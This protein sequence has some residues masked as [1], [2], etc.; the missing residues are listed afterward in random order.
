MDDPQTCVHSRA[1]GILVFAIIAAFAPSLCAQKFGRETLTLADVLD[2]A[3]ELAPQLPRVGLLPG[4]TTVVWQVQEMPGRVEVV[5]RVDL[6]TRGTTRLFNGMTLRIALRAA[7]ST[8]PDDGAVPPFSFL[9][10]DRVRVETEDGVW[11]WRFG[12]VKAERLLPPL[13][14]ATAAA[15]APGDV[16]VAGIVDADLKVLDAAGREQRVTWDGKDQELEYGGAAHRAEFGI[17]GGLFWDRDGNQ[18]AFYREDMKE[19]APYPY[20]DYRGLDVAPRHG[21]YPMAGRTHSRVQV[22]IFD[23]RDG[24]LRWLM[25]DGDPDVYWTNVTWAPDGKSICVALVTRDQQRCDLVEFDAATGSPLRTLLTETDEQWVEPEHGPIFLPDGTGFLWFSAR[26]G[27]RQLW[28]HARDGAPQWR[29]TEGN[30]DFREFL[31]FTDDGAFAHAMASGPNPRENHLVQIRLGRPQPM[32]ALNALPKQT[33][34]TQWARGWHEC[35]AREDGVVIDR[36]SNL[37]SP[38]MVSLL[39]PGGGRWIVGAA[40]DPL[41]RYQIGRSEFFT[42]ET[43]DGAMLHG[44]AILPPFPDRLR[45]SPVLLYVYG[46]PKAQLVR[47]VWGGG[48]SLWLQ[49]MAS[50]GYVV[51]RCD[52]R[53]SPWRGIEFEQEVHRHLGEIEVFDQLSALDT[54][55]KLF[56]FA[57]KDRVGV[58]GW[59]YGGYM[60]LRLM[61]LAPQQFVCGV[62]GAPVTDWR[63]YETGYTE[64]Y[65]DLP[66]ENEDGYE[67]S[68]VLPF[69]ENLR[70]RLLLV[71]GTD[72]RTVMWSQSMAFL[73]RCVEHG[74]RVDFLPY[75]MQQHGLG[76]AARRHFLERMTSWFEELLPPPPQEA[77]RGVLPGVPGS[78]VS[79]KSEDA[80]R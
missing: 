43:A 45:K 12:T 5:D 61:T 71:Q 67:A 14:R 66:A 36:W 31:G 40:P 38:G 48:A 2:R 62:A 8:I 79:D 20:A 21:R 44:H 70:G 26:N 37:Q 33:I 10:A 34:L 4:E 49:Y 58:H 50:R 17:H 78:A 56:P 60:T 47:D 65:M 76:G 72:D 30:F 35:E 13:P 28:R 80:G 3:K 1:A 59:S 63:Q 74:K 73:Q 53:G 52:G 24:S 23:R 25:R 29:E 51:L 68:S 7:G 57:D 41:V 55:L 64:R 77:P 6:R 15:I 54:A 46:G 32:I 9:E 39:T 11:A 19:I 18:L 69:A 75:P 16:A 42:V 22:G 27:H